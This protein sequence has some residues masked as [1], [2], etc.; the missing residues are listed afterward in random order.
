MGGEKRKNAY[1]M[2]VLTSYAYSLIPYSVH[3]IPLSAHSSNMQ[4]VMEKPTESKV[5]PQKFQ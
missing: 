3:A 1:F 4:Y 5:N 2:D